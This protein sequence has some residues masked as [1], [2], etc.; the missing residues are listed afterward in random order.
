MHRDHKKCICAVSEKVI[1]TQAVVA[2]RGAV[3]LQDVYEKLAKPDLICPITG[4]KFKPEKHVLQLQ[5]AAS[6]FAAS[7]QVTAKLYRPTMT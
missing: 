1:T 2:V 3:M 5:K 7:G 4:K 6:G